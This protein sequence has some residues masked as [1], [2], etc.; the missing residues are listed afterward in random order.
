MA[1]PTLESIVREDL[2]EKAWILLCQR[3][4]IAALKAQIV[5]LTQQL[6][7]AKAAPDA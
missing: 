4:E 1:E 5:A 2:G 6:A 3:H 7:A